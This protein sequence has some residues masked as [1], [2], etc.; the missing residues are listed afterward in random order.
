[1][2]LPPVITLVAERQF[3]DGQTAVHLKIKNRLSLFKGEQAVRHQP[4]HIAF[5]VHIRY[6]VCLLYTSDAADE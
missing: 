2:D 1:M 4:G 5:L 6:F 3:I